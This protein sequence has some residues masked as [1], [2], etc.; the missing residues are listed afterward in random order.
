[1]FDEKVIRSLMSSE[2]KAIRSETK[3]KKGTTL[4]ISGL[5]LKLLI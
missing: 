3:L 1:V 5:L 2:F 4:E